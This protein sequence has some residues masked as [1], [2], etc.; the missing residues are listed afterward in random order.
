MRYLHQTLADWAEGNFRHQC[1]PMPL[2]VLEQ[3]RH[4]LNL[5]ISLFTPTDQTGIEL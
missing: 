2:P 3:V 4:D 1:P 5:F